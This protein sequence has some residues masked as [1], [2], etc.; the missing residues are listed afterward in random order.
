MPLTEPQKKATEKYIK[1]HYGRISL[2]YPNDFCEVLRKAAKKKGQ[3]LAGYVKQAI[4]E[5]IQRDGGH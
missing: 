5:R 1:M 2:A 4:E 3:S